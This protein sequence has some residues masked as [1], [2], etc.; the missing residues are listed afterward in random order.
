MDFEK[1]MIKLLEKNLT[2]R[3]FD[4]WSKINSRLPGIWDRLSSSSKK[5]HKRQDG[6]VPNLAEHT[7]EMLYAAVKLL[8]MFGAEP[9]TSYADSLLLSV[10]FHDSLKYGC[11]GLGNG[12]HTVGSHDKLAADMIMS[13]EAT[14]RKI[15]N[16]E[17]FMILE[18]S[19][20]FHSGRWST[21]VP[22]QHEFDV[23]DFKPEAIFLHTLDMLSTADL[24]KLP[25]ETM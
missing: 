7:C 9:R 10:M 21:D 4:L 2:N 13:N 22:N 14:F 3:A 12:G 15:L 1:W 18:E 25:E 8:R 6:R 11:D 19:V 5:Y 17:E 20:R 23:Y 16:K 24:I